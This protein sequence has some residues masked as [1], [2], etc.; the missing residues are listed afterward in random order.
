MEP[1]GCSCSRVAPRPAVLA[2]QWRRKGRVVSMTASQSGKTSVGGA[3]SFARR[4]RTMSSIAEV[5]T[6]AASFLRRAVIG[7][8]RRAMSGRNLR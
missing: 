8:I 3:A 2:S 7:W 5:K 6:N 1:S 4:A